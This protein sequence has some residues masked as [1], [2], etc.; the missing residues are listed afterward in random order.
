[1]TKTFE[2]YQYV[3]KV[4]GIEGKLTPETVPLIREKLSNPKEED[5]L[6][7]IAKEEF[8][9]NRDIAQKI[10]GFINSPTPTQRKLL[11]LI[12]QKSDEIKRV[13]QCF[14][15]KKILEDMGLIERDGR[16]V[17]EWKSEII[18]NY[19]PGIEDPRED[20]LNSSFLNQRLKKAPPG[21]RIKQSC[22]IILQKLGKRVEKASDEEIIKIINSLSSID[23]R[24]EVVE[25]PRAI[26]G[27]KRSL[28]AKLSTGE[29]RRILL[30]LQRE[31]EDEKNAIRLL[32]ITMKRGAKPR[33]LFCYNCLDY[34]IMF[35]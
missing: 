26:T 18:K 23:F 19:W 24:D 35:I 32:K 22:K 25:K 11:I 33:F 28:K 29:L 8:S 2:F 17:K 1:L 7:R 16:K 9:I 3:K 5:N 27:T 10:L 31:E 34:F 6:L 13:P 15:N 20:P 21:Y 4:C 12:S 30:A 14:P